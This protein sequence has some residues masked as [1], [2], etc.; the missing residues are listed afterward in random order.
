MANDPGEWYEE[1]RQKA[2]R[3]AAELAGA[4]HVLEAVLDAHERRCSLIHVAR[5]VVKELERA[6]ETARYVGD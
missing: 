6:L 4:R 1:R 5:I 3:L 2:E